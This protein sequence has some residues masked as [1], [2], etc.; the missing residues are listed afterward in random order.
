[1][2]K[3]LAKNSKLVYFLLGWIENL[4]DLTKHYLWFGQE[5]NAAVFFRSNSK[6]DPTFSLLIGFKGNT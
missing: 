6:H 5:C 1:M 4:D 2:M 3:I